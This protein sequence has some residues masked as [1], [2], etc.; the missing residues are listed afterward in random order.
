MSDWQ[1]RVGVEADELEAKIEKLECFLNGQGVEEIDMEVID[2][3][4]LQLSAMKQYNHIL[5]MRIV[6]FKN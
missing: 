3:L 5:S 4:H 6:K 1:E 2:L